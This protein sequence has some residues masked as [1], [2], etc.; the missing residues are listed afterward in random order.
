MDE[1]VE[2]TP[3]V[4]KGYSLK[5]SRSEYAGIEQRWILVESEQRRQSD[6]KQLA[7]KIEQYQHKCLQEFQTLSTQEFACTADAISAAENL[8]KT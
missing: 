4:I 1:V 3:S 8:S 5:E 2:L 6:L 7:K